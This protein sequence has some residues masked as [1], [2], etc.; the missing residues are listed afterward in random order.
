MNARL[1]PSDKGKQTKPAKLLR[2]KPAAKS[3]QATKTET[4]KLTKDQA[5][6]KPAKPAKPALKTHQRGQ[7]LP[8]VPE[9]KRK[10]WQI[11]RFAE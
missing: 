4:V 5:S 11:L 8:T 6:A 3:K 1:P 2:S 9:K 10:W 7:S